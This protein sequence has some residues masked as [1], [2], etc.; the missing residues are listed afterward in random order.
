MNLDERGRSASNELRRVFG[1]AD[2]FGAGIELM[3]LHAERARRARRQRWRAGLV[4]AAISIPA[5]ALLASVFR[6]LSPA[7]P[8]TPAPTGTILYGRWDPDAQQSRW[9]T[10]NADGTDVRGLGVKVTCARWWPDGSK[11]LITNDSAYGPGRPL[12]PAT[13]LADG[14]G[15]EPLDAT[16]DRTLNLG[17]GDVSPDGQLLV[18]EGFND[19]EEGHNGIYVVRASDGGGLRQVVPSP[20]GGYDADPVFSPDGTRVAFFASKPGVSPP[21]AG[22]LFTVN[23]DGSGLRRISPWGGAF[24]DQGWSPDGSWIAYQRPYG[25]ITLVHPDGSDRHDVPVSLPVGTGAS[26]PTWS[27]DGD[28]IIFSL[29]DNG[30]ANIYRMRPD[31]SSL[32]QVTTERD[33]DEQ[34]PFWTSKIR[35]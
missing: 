9:F 5:V 17:C 25:V 32:T 11:I 6:D 4:A 30:T 8:A 14:S 28:W 22:A 31:G 2:R 15:L 34:T 10:A 23:L 26:N 1:S 35:T 18:L 13:V 20:R 27:P 21:G 24:L 12:R 19:K 7:V 29:A 33:V 3:R 16:K